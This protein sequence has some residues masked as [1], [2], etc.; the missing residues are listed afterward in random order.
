MMN[1]QKIIFPQEID[2]WYVLPAIRKELA[3]ALVEL[4]LKQKDVAKL[5]GITEAAVSQYKNEKRAKELV[6]EE[7]VKAEIKKSAQRI[8]DNP[9]VAFNEIMNIDDYLKKSGIFCQIHRSKSWTPAGCEATCNKHFF[10]QSEVD[11]KWQN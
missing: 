1:G 6:F 4:G 11:I 2:V 3:M 8:K 9:Q 7:N 10:N 5:L